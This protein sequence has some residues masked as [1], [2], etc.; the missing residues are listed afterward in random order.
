[1]TKEREQKISDCYKK[2]AKEKMGS[3]IF[4]FYATLCVVWMLITSKNKIVYS[5]CL[6]G[7]SI[8]LIVD[9]VITIINLK[10]IKKPKDPIKAELWAHRV[11][12][13]HWK[14]YEK[15]KYK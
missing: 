8:I 3:T 9:I 6:S 14:L 13:D 11:E 1:M 7:F 4:S 12:T 2:R 5:I 10:R 15:R